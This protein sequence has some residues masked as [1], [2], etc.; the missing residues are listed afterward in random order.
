MIAKRWLY[1]LIFLQIIC[2]VQLCSAKKSKKTNDPSKNLPC[3]VRLNDTKNVDLKKIETAFDITLSPD[4]ERYYDASD[5]VDGWF[6]KKLIPIYILIDMFQK[7]TGI[8]G[9]LAEIGVWQGKSFIPLMHLARQNEYVVAIDCFESYE[10]NR[11]NSGGF[12][13]SSPF[14]NNVNAYCSDRSKL[15]ILKGDSLKLSFNDYLLSVG[16]GKGFRLFSVDGCHEADTTLADMENAYKCL[17]DGGVIVMDDY[18]HFC[19]PGVSE[20]VNTF[21]NRNDN[22]LKPFLIAFNKIFFA[23]PDYA[24]K[25]FDMIQKFLVPGDIRIKKFFNVEILIN[26]PQ[27]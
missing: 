1:S 5:K 15:R 13:N 8:G 21:M 26:D 7:D 27:S 24:K 25:Y 20:G 12:C 17:V 22:C 18:F 23:R 14:L 3:V 16:N 11:D 2:C 4:V 9:N 6:D 10:F 19:W